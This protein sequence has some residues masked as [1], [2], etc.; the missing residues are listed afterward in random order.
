MS[1]V[2]RL[3]T[4]EGAFVAVMGEPG[5]K[6]TQYV[7]LEA[8]PV[9]ARKIPNAEAERFS[10]ELNYPI[11][12]AVRNMRGAGRRHGITKGAR[13]LLTRALA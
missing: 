8:F 2:V 6:F 7:S 5:R 4:S 3:R 12:K 1:K 11:R 13:Q 9:R 10:T